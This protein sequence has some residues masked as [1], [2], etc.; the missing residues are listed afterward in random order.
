MTNKL[1]RYSICAVIFT[2]IPMLALES[3]AGGFEQ[4][5]A[6]SSDLPDPPKSQLSTE[7]NILASRLSALEAEINIFNKDCEYVTIG[8]VK[9]GECME[10][11]Q[12]L[13]SS[14][15]DW[16]SDTQVFCRKVAMLHKQALLM[17]AAF[18]MGAEVRA[19]VSTTL[20][21]I[22]DISRVLIGVW[23]AEQGR[24]DKARR[25]AQLHDI[26]PGDKFFNDLDDH[27]LSLWEEQQALIDNEIN[28]L[29]IT[30]EFDKNILPRILFE[31]LMQA[32]LSVNSGDYE[33]A[34]KH[35]YDAKI[36]G[37]GNSQAFA[38]VELFVRQM[39]VSANEKLSTP[40]PSLIEHQRNLASSYASLT[41]GL[42]LMEAQMDTVAIQA[43]SEA[44]DKFAKEGNIEDSKLAFKLVDNVSRGKE[45][46]W[47]ELRLPRVY[48]GAS[49]AHILL[50]ALEY[51]RGDWN[52]SL[53]FLKLA[54]DAQPNNSAIGE[55]LALTR[56]LAA[57]SR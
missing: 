33:T 36:Y 57:S 17:G 5:C 48:D 49:E 6:I 38:D 37:F 52:R 13:L 54:R 40:D 34:L 9:D 10:R 28:R 25:M 47:K 15:A 18:K 27:W 51:G 53:K 39:K 8:S 42:H 56:A 19:Y 11:N 21:S 24:Y 12:S 26:K 30:G 31:S 41:L 32:H 44:A 50:D 35:I 2:L 14:Q 1:L 4:L 3:R 7:R 45:R 20:S 29:V 16:N 46:K 23:Q 55:A 43:L 22:T